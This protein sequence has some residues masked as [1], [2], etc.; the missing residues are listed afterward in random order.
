[1]TQSLSMTVTLKA[2]PAEVFQA[3]T[4]AQAIRQWSGQAGKVEAKIGG[5]FGMF[6]GWVKGSVLAYQEGKVLAYTWLPEDWPVGT[7]PS[8]VR[9]SFSRTK[10]GTK[11][12]LKHSGLP[13]ARQKKE[14]HD[15]WIEH[16][17][18]PLKEYFQSR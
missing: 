10:Y 2:K 4:N 18:E 7:E 5:R 16:V 3:L 8:I 13:D 1:M 6:D 17:F 15:G 14:H 9:F 12:V 11:I